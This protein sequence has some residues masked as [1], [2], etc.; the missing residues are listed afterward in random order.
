MV[1]WKPFSFLKIWWLELNAVMVTEKC[2]VI[3]F[4]LTYY[5]LHWAAG[6]EWYIGPNGLFGPRTPVSQSTIEI[7]STYAVLILLILSVFDK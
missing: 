6:I 3:A 2:I 5:C 1:F 7:P 4:N